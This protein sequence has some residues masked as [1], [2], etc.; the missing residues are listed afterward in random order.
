MSNNALKRINQMTNIKRDSIA[1]INTVDVQ[2]CK[3][4]QLDPQQGAIITCYKGKEVRI[5]VSGLDPYEDTHSPTIIVD[6]PVADG[7]GK[8]RL[9]FLLNLMKQTQFAKSLLVK[10]DDATITQSA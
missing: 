6:L 5:P 3:E 4:L 10:R 1:I 8:K 9:D 7:L 2:R